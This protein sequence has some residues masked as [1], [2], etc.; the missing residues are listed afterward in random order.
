[1]PVVPDDVLDGLRALWAGSR[2]PS[3]VTGGLY[4]GRAT[5]SAQ[6]PYAAIKAT[7]GDREEF[8]GTAYLQRYTVEVTV[9][10]SDAPPEMA[11]IRRELSRLLDRTADLSIPNARVVHVR[12]RGG[13]L[14]VAAAQQ[15]ANDVLIAAGT[16]DVLVESTRE[17]A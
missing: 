9:W 12:G 17:S 7:E 16:W 10:S 15:D 4:H 14:E 2:M 8:S 6:K 13:R 5:T 1:M 11:E 3:L